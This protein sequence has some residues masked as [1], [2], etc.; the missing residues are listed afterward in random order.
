MFQIIIFL[1]EIGCVLW[2][3]FLVMALPKKDKTLFPAITDVSLFCHKLNILFI[4]LFCLL[5]HSLVLL[6][7]WNAFLWLSYFG[8]PYDLISAPFP[9]KKILIYFWLHQVLVAGTRI[10]LLRHMD[11]VVTE[12]GFTCP[13]ALGILVPWTRIEPASSALESG[14]LTTWPPGKSPLH[15]FLISVTNQSL[16]HTPSGQVKKMCLFFHQHLVGRVKSKLWLFLL[17]IIL[18]EPGMQSMSI[19]LTTESQF[20]SIMFVWFK[21][22]ILIVWC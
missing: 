20:K 19:E 11:L 12:C 6:C 15:T 13:M 17:T 21:Q 4:H 22:L 16:I 18:P 8:R 3:T 2:L 14:L 7:D 9:L 10:L 1:L 5:H